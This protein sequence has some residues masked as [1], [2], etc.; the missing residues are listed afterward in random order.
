M[1]GA[2]LEMWTASRRGRLSRAIAGVCVAL[3]VTGSVSMLH[4]SLT[5]QWTTAH[6]PQS[7]SN[8][9]QHTHGSCAWHCDGIE[10]QSSSADHGDRLLLR[11]DFCSEILPTQYTPRFLRAGESSVVRLIRFSPDP[12]RPC[13]E[14]RL[15]MKDPAQQNQEGCA[16]EID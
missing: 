3:W 8:S 15:P 10:S 4:G 16:Y 2:F 11:P 1:I 9:A 6:C 14:G 12:F 7:H 13:Y 5:P